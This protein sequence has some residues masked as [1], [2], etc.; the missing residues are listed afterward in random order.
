MPAGVFDGLTSLRHLDLYHNYLN[1][2][3]V[4]VFDKLSRGYLINAFL[5]ES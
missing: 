2:L 4:G 1:A 3:P 5:P